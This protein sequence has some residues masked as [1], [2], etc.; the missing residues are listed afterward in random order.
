MSSTPRGRGALETEVLAL[1]GATGRP[2]TASEV[3][4]ELGLKLAYTTVMTTL[5]RLYR[6]GALIR[7]SSGRAFTY[8]LAGSPADVD[9]AVVAHKMRAVLDAGNDRAGVL[10]R[11]VADLTPGDEQ[12]LTE[13][14]ASGQQPETDG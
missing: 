11:F 8:A 13:L 7:D 1:L 4:E 5:A 14:L 2:M 3:L 6:K 9:T 12:M 10:A